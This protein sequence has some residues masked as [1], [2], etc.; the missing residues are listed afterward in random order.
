MQIQHLHPGPVALPAAADISDGS[1]P[2][3]VATGT[4]NETPE[5]KYLRDELRTRPGYPVFLKNR[6]RVLSNP[7]VVKDW[8]FAV[9]FSQD[10]NKT[11]TPTVTIT[12]S[13]VYSGKLL[14]MTII[15]TS[16]KYPLRGGEDYSLTFQDKSTHWEN[17]DAM[18]SIELCFHLSSHSAFQLNFFRSFSIK[19][20]A[21]NGTA[22]VTRTDTSTS[23]AT[24]VPI[25]DLSRDNLADGPEV[26]LGAFFGEPTP[27]PAHVP[28]TADPAG[29]TS[30]STSTAP[31][32]PA[33]GKSRQRNA[34]P[35]PSTPL[36]DTAAREFLAN[37]GLGEIPPQDRRYDGKTEGRALQRDVH[38]LTQNTAQLFAEFRGS[39][40]DTI[41]TMTG[42]QRQL[43][44][45]D[46][47]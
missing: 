12:I 25:S 44:E 31:P 19:M 9:N 38:S 33:R 22:P 18:Q 37:V 11:K 26:D 29:A 43:L 1:S 2:S 16:P 24:T 7:D 10:Y 41:N 23:L 45:F 5:A 4:D 30:A 34:S 14:I 3:I 36:V 20:S 8:R 28:A 35:G 13:G 27:A 40:A 46:S 39:R 32:S 42:F 17:W 6:G 21:I 15:D 47:G